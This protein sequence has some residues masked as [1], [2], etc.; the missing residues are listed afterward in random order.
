MYATG[1]PDQHQPA[2]DI[3]SRG[4]SGSTQTCGA[5]RC[6]V[7]NSGHHN[8]EAPPEIVD[9]DHANDR[10]VRETE[11]VRD[12]LIRNASRLTRQRADAEDLVQETLLKAYSS[13]DSYR[14]GTHLK[15]WLS[16]IMANAW[17]D[18]HRST[19][20][21]P[22]EQL[23]ADVTDLPTVTDGGGHGSRVESAEAQALQALPSEAELALR[24]LP[25]D[26]RAIVYYACIADYRNTEIAAMLDIPVGT[27]GSRLHRGK[28]LL[29]DALTGSSAGYRSTRE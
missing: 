11:P 20:R 25:D 10:F 7:A 18:K 14:E 19:Q 6:L 17:I 2:G 12:F 16:R 8:T 21:R 9:Q 27:V 29:R 26:V 22:I 24:R 3:L 5:L 4:C 15:S 23:S 13:F 1:L 28:A